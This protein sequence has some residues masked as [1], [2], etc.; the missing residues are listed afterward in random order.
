MRAGLPAKY[1]QYLPIIPRLINM[2]RHRETVERL[3][4]RS[5]CRPSSDTISDIFDGQHDKRLHRCRVVVDGERLAHRFF[6]QP[7]DIALGLSSDGFGPFKSRKKTC[8]PLLAFN[9]NLKPH[10]RF[11]LKNLICLGVIPGPLQPKDIGSFLRPFIDELEDLARGVPA[12]DALNNR[13]FCLHAYLLDCFGDMPA[14]AKLMYMKGHNGKHPCRACRICGVRNP[15][16]STEDDN[17]TNYVPLSRPFTTGRHEPRRFDPLDLPRRSHHQFILQA[18]QVESAPTDAEENRRSRHFGINAL[19]PLARLSSLDFPASF[20]HDFMHAIFENVIPT[21]IDLWTHSGRRF[22]NFGTGRENYVLAADVWKDI[23]LA[24]AQSGS[25]IP[26]AFGCRVPNLAQER[27]QTTAESTLLFATLLA[28]ALLRHQF[29]SRVYYTH[30]IELVRLINL[31]LDFELPRRDLRT[32]RE[33]FAKWVKD[34]E[35][36]VGVYVL[37]VHVQFS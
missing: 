35:R 32:V 19:S 5:T 12:Y 33:G 4:Y 22:S 37:W 16:P 6:S 1:F 15:H 24:C 9:Y 23:G 11:R 10:I 7:T 2:Y 30:F 29:K 36:S 20:P 25:T 21:L 8:W 28:P 26:S 13:P 17:K 18:Q 3:A 31:C 34:Y 27:A 14:V